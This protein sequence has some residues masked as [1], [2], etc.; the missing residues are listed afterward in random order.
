MITADIQFDGMNLDGLAGLARVLAPLLKAGDL[1]LLTGEIGA[2]KTAFARLLIRALAG[3]PRLDVPSPAFALHQVYDTARLRISH[4]DFYR[5]KDELEVAE[6]GLDE[7]LAGDLVIAEWPER[8]GGRLPASRLEIVFEE[9]ADPDRRR[10]TFAAREA[11]APR[12][13]RFKPILDLLSA[14]GWDDAAMEP[15]GGDASARVYYRLRRAGEAALLMDW[16]RQPD[17]PP[18]R[19]GLPYSRVAHLAE[20]VT[21]FAAIAGALR[22]AGIAAPHILAQD[23]DAGLLLIEDFGD[24]V[25]QTMA[26]RGED[27]RPY[28]PAAVDALVALRFSPPPPVITAGEAVHTLP[29]YD[30]QALG[31]EVELL[32]DWYVP[33]VTGN[34]ARDD[35]SASFLDLWAEHIGWLLAHGESA[36]V[37]RDY[38]SPNLIWRAGESGLARLGVIDFQDALIGHSAY[39]LVSLLQ[40][41]RIDLPAGLEAEMFEAYCTAVI[42]RKPD[43]D[44]TAFARAYAVLGA[45]RNTKILGIFARLAMRDGKRGYLQHLP[46]IQRYVAQ[47]LAHPALAGLKTWMECELPA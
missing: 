3:N 15:L 36:W 31:I 7:A 42:A 45:Q 27:V 1:L 14:A 32:L 19:D 23:L 28:Y 12:L 13:A 10:L 17:G 40:D 35:Q 30:A 25:Y 4:F 9:T 33:F 37:L 22:D 6:L 26:R 44:R 2:G 16:P 39:D 38:H 47:N 11:F 21:P 18:I 29:R 34:P 20:G 8:A 43:F 41:A 46:R 5:L 24:E